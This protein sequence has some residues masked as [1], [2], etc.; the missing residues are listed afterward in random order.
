MYSRKYLEA[1][2]SSSTD[3][4]PFLDF[5][6]DEAIRMSTAIQHR[7]IATRK[8]FEKTVLNDIAG[9]EGSPSFEVICG[10]VKV[11]KEKDLLPG[12]SGLGVEMGSGLG[13]L[14]AA[15][16]KSDLFPNIEGILA[17]EAGRPFAETGIRLAADITLVEESFKLMPCHGS[18][19]SIPVEDNSIDFIVQIEA[20]HHAESLTGP[21]KE[22]FRILRPGGT[23]IS[24]DRSWP[25]EVEESVLE[26]LLNHQYSKDWLVEKGF[27]SEVPFTR[28][29]NGEH[30][31]V[32]EYW[33]SA[34]E[35]VGFTCLVFRHLHPEF[36]FWHLAK[37]LIGILSLNNLAGIKV[38]S[39]EGTIRGFLADQ[40]RLPIKSKTAVILSPHPRPLTVS[41]WRK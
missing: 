25:D 14:S 12:I 9:L 34:F 17:I 32:D 19:D 22:A 6:V 15:F 36:R 33:K 11:L 5:E 8:S 24:I 29:E 41:V 40:L 26:E 21:I 13:L 27:P 18:F 4:P 39:R 1:I 16:I 3:R 2:L 37:R 28:R 20:L 30:E 7:E 23:F 38:P 35:T 10:L 31:Y